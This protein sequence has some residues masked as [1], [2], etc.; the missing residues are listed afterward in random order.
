MYF[1]RRRPAY[2][3][4]ILYLASPSV[5]IKQKTYTS[6]PEISMSDHRP[7]SANFNISTRSVDIG[8]YYRR[9]RELACRLG[10]FEESE[11]TPHL[12]VS[13]SQVS[14][15]DVRYDVIFSA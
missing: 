11:E 4:R 2:T 13:T 14:F 5:D 6:H 10:H 8:G 9:A 3:D 15:G 12:N 1:L 7:V